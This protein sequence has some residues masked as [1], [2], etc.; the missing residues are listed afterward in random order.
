MARRNPTHRGVD[1]GVVG[2]RGAAQPNG[3]ARSG[4]RALSRWG[5][6]CRGGRRAALRDGALGLPSL[7][8]CLARTL[9]RAAVVSWSR[10]AR[11]VCSGG[12]LRRGGARSGG[13]SGPGLA[14]RAELLT[15]GEAHEVAVPR[16]LKVHAPEPDFEPG[17]EGIRAAHRLQPLTIPTCSSA[18]VMIGRSS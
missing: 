6:G 18:Y 14:P 10:R 2:R 13:R 15:V 7:G 8:P 12:C 16:G 9:T 1:V 4:D 11:S 17:G 3:K 5:G